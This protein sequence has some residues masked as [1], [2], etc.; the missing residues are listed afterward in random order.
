LS[1]KCGE[2]RESAENSRGIEISPLRQ[3]QPNPSTYKEQIDKQNT[4]EFYMP[5][6][7]HAYQDAATHVT[8]IAAS[9]GLMWRHK[10]HKKIGDDD[11]HPDG[12]IVQTLNGG[13]DITPTGRVQSSNR[14]STLA[15]L[16]D[17]VLEDELNHRN[18]KAAYQ[19]P[20]LLGYRV[21]R[22]CLVNEQIHTAHLPGRRNRGCRNRRNRQRQGALSETTEDAT[23]TSANEPSFIR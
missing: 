4:V 14:Y 23:V 17:T 19:E 16:G 7:K 8:N 12:E 13:T 20:E 9:A 18:Y 5:V 2:T 1:N 22:V 3:V 15:F 6:E 11:E 21:P 10:R